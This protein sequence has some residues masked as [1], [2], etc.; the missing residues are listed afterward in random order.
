MRLEAPP[1]GNLAKTVTLVGNNP[2]AGAEV[3]VLTPFLADQL[4]L[5]VNRKGIVVIDIK[6]GSSA[7]R[8]GFLPSD[9]IVS[10]LGRKLKS[11]AQFEEILSAGASFWRLEII[12]PESDQTATV[13]S[14]TYGES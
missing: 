7:A 1:K 9:V 8:Y 6:R 5:P 13:R 2:F 4:K 3:T 10:V 12:K 11:I 14:Y